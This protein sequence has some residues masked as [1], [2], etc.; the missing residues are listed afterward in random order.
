MIEV[1]VV[2]DVNCISA[3]VLNTYYI[4]IRI[5]NILP[6]N[7]SVGTVFVKLVVA[8]LINIIHGSVPNPSVYCNQIV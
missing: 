7:I 2:T 4:P 5:I 8:K 1:R 3:A 6:V